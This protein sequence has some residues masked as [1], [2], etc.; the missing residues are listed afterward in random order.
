MRKQ[1]QQQQ[2][3]KMTRFDRTIQGQWEQAHMMLH[4]QAQY[5]LQHTTACL[6]TP[7]QAAALFRVQRWVKTPA[8]QRMA[9]HLEASGRLLPPV[10][11]WRLDACIVEQHVQRPAARLEVITH[12]LDGP[13]AAA[14]AAGCI[15]MCSQ[16][17]LLAHVNR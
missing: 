4:F 16:R 5:G 9:A 15:Y 14:A 1:Q 6:P 7:S 12:G 10:A 8:W 2:R 17:V 11:Q 3:N 13:A